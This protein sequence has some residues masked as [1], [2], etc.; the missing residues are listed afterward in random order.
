MKHILAF[1]LLGFG[2]LHSFGQKGDGISIEKPFGWYEDTLSKL[3]KTILLGESDAVKYKANNQF[4]TLLKEA[5][6][7]EGAFDYPFDSL[8]TIANLKAP[9]GKFRLFNWHIRKSNVTF[10]YFGFFLY[11]NEVKGRYF[12]TELNDKSENIVRPEY[13]RNL[14][15]DNWYGCHY[16]TIVG[17]K[18]NNKFYTLIGWD[19]NYYNMQRK[20]IETVR[21]NG[22]GEPKFGGAK[23][24]TTR[25]TKERLFIQYSSLVS[26]TLRYDIK[27]KMIIFDHLVPPHPSMTGRYE[28]YR[29]SG[30]YNAFIFNRNK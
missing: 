1:I 7:K 29:P 16:Y 5:L 4:K 8:L 26:A 15:K 10:E 22:K 6:N 19:G 13:A 20:I 27:N 30:M 17:K 12:L 23:L 25:G 24:K 11:F 9:D 2:C 14:N 18:K 3:S 21:F 28:K